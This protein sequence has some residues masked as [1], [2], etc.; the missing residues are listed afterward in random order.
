M[1][2]H[3]RA[4]PSPFKDSTEC[5]A[6]ICPQ[7]PRLAQL[8]TAQEE[9]LGRQFRGELQCRTGAAWLV[10]GEEL[11]EILSPESP[12]FVGEES[13]DF[14]TF[15]GRVA[16]ADAGANPLPYSIGTY[17]NPSEG[18]AI[19]AFKRHLP[20]PEP[21]QPE[22][23]QSSQ[24][25]QS[26]TNQQRPNLN[27]PRQGNVSLLAL[28]QQRSQGLAY[29]EP[30]EQMQCASQS[31]NSM[32]QHHAATASDVAF[33]LVGRKIDGLETY[34]ANLADQKGLMH[35]LVVQALRNKQTV[36]I[37]KADFMGNNPNVICISTDQTIGESWQNLVNQS[38]A[39]QGKS[40][41]ANRTELES[42]SEL[43][44]TA[45]HWLAAQR[46]TEMVDL[47]NL[48]N[49]KLQQTDQTHLPPAMAQ[50]NM[51]DHSTHIRQL[52]DLANR[53]IA[54][55]KD[56]P[57][58]VRTGA[59]AEAGHYQTIVPDSKGNWL[60][61]NADQTQLRG[62]QHCNQ[63]CASGDLFSSLQRMGA[64]NILVPVFN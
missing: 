12:R 4:L 47:L 22:T 55:G 53:A 28:L 19:R 14:E 21:G 37:S 5:P 13:C 59:D 34:G 32:L 27:V 42:I 11:L 24:A 29:K 56:F 41:V 54:Q 16:I 52:E 30:L 17:N 62:V 10:A 3:L 48:V 50:L 45:Y 40:W 39:A 46:G 57:I 31:V 9:N 7:M 6:I 18:A 20:N 38:P 35:P 23:G 60:S 25:A 63:W 33:Y 51:T 15:F 43:E 44:V 49:D 58:I 1:D 61:L 2:N 64:N 26:A 8:V 36:T